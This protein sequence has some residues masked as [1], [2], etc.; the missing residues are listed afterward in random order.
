MFP[1]R[2]GVRRAPPAFTLIELLVVIAIIAILI[3]LLLPAVQKIREAA[4]RMKCQNHLKQLALACHNHHDTYGILPQ[5]GKYFMDSYPPAPANHPWSCHYNK[6]SWLVHTLPF[7]EME[8][9]HRDIPYKEYFNLSLVTDPQ[10]DSIQ[11]AIVQGFLPRKL[12]YLRCPSDG[13]YTRE[14]V[15]NYVGSVGPAC[16][17]GGPYQQYCDPLA[18]GL[19]DWG[20]RA[21]SFGGFALDPERIRGCFSPTGGRVNFAMVIDG[22]SNTILLGET[23]VEEHGWMLAYAGAGGWANGMGGNTH[24]STIIPINTSSKLNPNDVNIA[25]GFKSKHT[26]GTNFAMVDGSV[27]F[28]RQDIN[29]RTYQLLGCRHDGDVPPRYG[30][31]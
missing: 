14:H 8:P 9:L 15:S 4:A 22:L 21:S 30:E 7:M 26:G 16:L 3:G 5:G 11:Q 19:G 27:K 17:S 12:P 31:Y 28:F 10:N 23:V 6:G 18:Y 29:H 20:Y 13:T 1:S 2:S 24:C 25:W